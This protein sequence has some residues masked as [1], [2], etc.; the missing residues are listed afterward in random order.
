MSDVSNEAIR[1]AILACESE[2]GYEFD[3]NE[4]V[5]GIIEHYADLSYP[6]PSLDEAKDR[7][8]EIFPERFAFGKNKVMKYHGYQPDSRRD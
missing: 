5:D 2:N 8:R 4:L 3:F 6:E 1:T 7:V